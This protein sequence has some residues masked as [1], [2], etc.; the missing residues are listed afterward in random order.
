MTAVAFD[1]A[2]G[3][4]RLTAETF[5]ALV[6]VLAGGRPA[7]SEEAELDALA[8][9]GAL[10]ATGPHELLVPG[11]AAVVA[12]L[13][14][15]RVW[16]TGSAGE[17]MHQGWISREAAALLLAVEGTT[18]EFLTLL[19]EHVPTVV[20][21]VV[22]LGPRARWNEQV[23][24]ETVQATRADID[25]VLSEHHR[26]REAGVRALCTAAG[27]SMSAWG[28]AL[29]SGPWRAW[30]AEVVWEIP[31]GEV[32]GRG[33]VAVDTEQGILI[34]EPTADDGVLL[35]PT[36]PTVIWRAITRLLPSDGEIAFDV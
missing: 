8:S 17:Q 13:C 26:E 32:A 33:I 20:A 25:A 36:S 35:R 6:G 31:G 3:S 11:L 16:V 27:P 7:P 4:L 14:Q 23:R 28:E 34:A 30:H 9:S 19:P 15:V 2:S 10:G 18:Y 5:E 29:R 12:P 24:L 1:P 22:R 21:A